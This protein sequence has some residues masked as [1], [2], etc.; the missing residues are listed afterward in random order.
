MEINKKISASF[1]GQLKEEYFSSYLYLSMAA[2]FDN[3]NLPGFANWMK[4]QASEEFK[5]AMKFY[6]HIA[7]RN[8]RVVLEQID[9]P[10]SEWASP[11]E[12]FEDA[13]KHEQKITALIH[14]LVKLSRDEKDYSA[15]VFLHWFV[16][17]QVEEEEQTRAILDNLKFIGDAKQG[18]MM[19]DR[20]LAKRE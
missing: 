4:I 17:E 18:L 1:N 7:E 12:A 10:K 3:E 16:D 8:G 9:K 6:K 5:H 20:E 19:L 2:Y 15:E 11:V 14:D 13:Y